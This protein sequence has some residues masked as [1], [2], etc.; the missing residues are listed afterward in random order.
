MVQQNRIVS[1]KILR[2]WLRNN[3]SSVNNLAS[4]LNL[5]RYG[6]P[7]LLRRHRLQMS[8]VYQ[9]EDHKRG[10]DPLK[11]VHQ[12]IRQKSSDLSLQCLRIAR[13]RQLRIMITITQSLRNGHFPIDHTRIRCFHLNRGPADKLP[14][15]RWKTVLH[16][17]TLHTVCCKRKQQAFVPNVMIDFSRRKDNNLDQLSHVQTAWHRPRLL[18]RRMMESRSVFNGKR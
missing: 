4:P 1:C 2:C 5:G 6:C 9:T 3:R 14:R 17:H 7:L 10:W 18:I 11:I 16:R 12:H 13:R 15:N 8:H